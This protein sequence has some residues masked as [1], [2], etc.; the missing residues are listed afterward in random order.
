MLPHHVM[1]LL[2][3]KARSKSQGHTTASKLD[4]NS[5]AI[6]SIPVVALKYK[7][8][9]NF[10]YRK[11][12]RKSFQ[13]Q[14]FPIPKHKNSLLFSF[15]KILIWILKFLAITMLN[16]FVFF[17]FLYFIYIF[18]SQKKKNKTCLICFLTK[19]KTV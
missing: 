17:Y 4:D 11:L 2:Y 18:L 9:Y 14:K 19:K 15:I 12:K 1:N 7:I 10:Y 8:M 5:I 16:K 6:N 13:F 3:S